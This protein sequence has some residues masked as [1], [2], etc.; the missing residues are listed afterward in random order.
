MA[1][2][3]AVLRSALNRHRQTVD[4]D[5]GFTLEPPEH[6]STPL[7]WHRNPVV[8]FYRRLRSKYFPF[9]LRDLRKESRRTPE[10]IAED[11]DKE[12][13]PPS[14]PK[15]YD[16]YGSE[17][18]EELLEPPP[19]VS[20]FGLQVDVADWTP[21]SNAV[22]PLPSDDSSSEYWTSSSESEILSVSSTL[23]SDSSS[24]LSAKDGTTSSPRGSG[25]NRQ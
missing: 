11:E 6:T 19:N 14:T 22:N 25:S 7:I 3:A 10:E 8:Y 5:S 4:A 12:Y 2:R 23:S 15:S 17:A 21:P 24:Y 1:W 9:L 13:S 20:I 18:S 16:S